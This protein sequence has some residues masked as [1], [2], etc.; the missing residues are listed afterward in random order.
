MTDTKK[1]LG[2]WAGP[3]HVPVQSGWVCGD[4]GF[5]VVA[6]RNGQAFAYVR[7]ADCADKAAAK[8]RA[9]LIAETLNRDHGVFGSVSW[10]DPSGLQWTTEEGYTVGRNAHGQVMVRLG[11]WDSPK[12]PESSDAASSLASRVLR[13]KLPTGLYPAELATANPKGLFVAHDY[14]AEL[15]AAA[16]ALAGSVLRQDTTKGLRGLFRKLLGK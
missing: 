7:H 16:K 14:A 8:A 3:F 4:E 11:V 10:P 2:A 1:R 15:L 13:H 12:A 9:T 5:T 6:D